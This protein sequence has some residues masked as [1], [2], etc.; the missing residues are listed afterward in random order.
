VIAGYEHFLGLASRLQWD[1]AA[2]D[3]RPDA[4]AW[5]DHGDR[6]RLLPLIAG[7]CVGEA[8]VAEWLA[9][10]AA[11]ATPAAAACF[12]AQ[13]R[14]EQRHAR[15]FARV[16]REVAGAS[17]EGLRA[18]L[19]P[20]FLALFEVR[21]PQA[22]AGELGAAVGLYHMVLE[23]VVFT[24]GQ[25]ALLELLDDR[26]PG[27]RAGTELVLR[28][29]RWH[30]GF[31]TRCLQ[32]AGVGPEAEAAILAEGERAAVL[33]APD[34]AERVVATLRRRLGAVRSQ[35]ETVH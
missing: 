34:Q 12:R 21:L 26:L 2:I 24:A 33:W 8:S 19:S 30:V 4:A 18:H 35:R 13:E 1:D 11:A 32:D 31:G 5:P 10:F 23:G 22:A 20:E 9:P 6:E 25:L 7:F 28:D 3:L 15:F 14:D 17:P 29:E 16:A 27:L